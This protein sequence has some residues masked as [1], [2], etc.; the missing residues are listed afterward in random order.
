M[1]LSYEAAVAENMLTGS[2]LFLFPVT[3]TDENS[4]NLDY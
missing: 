3:V 1:C 2:K 4:C